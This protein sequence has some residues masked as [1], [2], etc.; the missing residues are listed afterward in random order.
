VSLPT[1]Q[2]HEYSMMQHNNRPVRYLSHIP[3]AVLT[4]GGGE[5]P[6]T[7]AGGVS[8]LGGKVDRYCT[9]AGALTL[10][11]YNARARAFVPAQMAEPYR[12]LCDA[13]VRERRK[14]PQVDAL[15]KLE[16][17]SSRLRGAGAGLTRADV[18][19]R[20]ARPK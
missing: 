14:S 10:A 5:G 15:Y 2:L 18:E 13:S 19:A 3:Y 4:E 16:Q 6:G 1:Q 17:E 7:I 20:R 12:F 11:E 9:T 8:S